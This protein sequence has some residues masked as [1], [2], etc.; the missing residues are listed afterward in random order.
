MLVEN[1]IYAVTF[2]PSD[3]YQFFG[4][5]D[6]F[7]TWYNSFIVHLVKLLSPY[8]SFKLFP[9]ISEEGGRLHLHGEIMFTDLFG[10]SL[11]VAHELKLIT[12]VDIDT[13]AFGGGWEMYCG[14]QKFQ[15]THMLD[16]CNKRSLPY[17]IN[18]KTIEKYIPDNF[19]TISHHDVTFLRNFN[20]KR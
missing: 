2:N 12:M 4:L 11:N 6:R 3:E 9:E 14:K 5:K 17:K 10:Y 16:N 13:I 19:H 1:K 18:K 7:E 20:R 8:T 15:N